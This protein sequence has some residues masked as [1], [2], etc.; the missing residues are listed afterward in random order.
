MIHMYDVQIIEPVKKHSGVADS[1]APLLVAAYCR[2]STK[3][4]AQ[5]KSLKSMSDYYRE[6]INSHEGWQLVDVYID[7]GKSGTK[8]GNRPELQRMMNDCR[9]GKI[10]YIITK[11]IS[12]LGRESE[13]LKM[14][15]QE[16][17]NRR[18]PIYFEEDRIDSTDPNC[19]F[20]LGIKSVISEEEVA[21]TSR[22]VALG[23]QMKMARGIMVG[24]PKCLGYDYNIE[25]KTI[26][27]NEEGAKTVRYIF[28]RYLNG[29]GCTVIARELNEKGIK[30]LRG[31]AWGT[32]SVAGIIKNE[33]YCG[34]LLQGK[35]VTI[36]PIN[37]VRTKNNGL[38]RQFRIENH[39]EP[40]ISRETFEQARELM[41]KRSQNRRRAA[42]GEIPRMKF[43]RQ[44]AFSSLLECGFC[45]KMLSRR[46]WHSGTPNQKTVWQCALATKKG[47]VFCSESKGMHEKIIEDA[48]L[49]AFSIIT[50]DNGEILDIFLKRVEKNLKADKVETEIR[51]KERQYEDVRN[52]LGKLIDS[53]L[54]GIIDAKVYKQKEAELCIERDAI[55][56]ELSE[57]NVIR[58]SNG[59]IEKKIEGMRKILDD[60]P[61][62][63]EF[64]RKIFE[65]VIEK[66]I[67]GGYTEDGCVDPY[68]LTF[69]F[70]TGYEYRFD[71]AKLRFGEGNFVM[72]CS[73]GIEKNVYSH[74]VDKSYSHHS[75]NSCGVRGVDVKS[76]Q[77]DREKML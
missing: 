31:N 44:Y 67:V 50:A 49:E 53:H 39:H 32:S 22:H 59:S 23:K 74:N 76:G 4:E 18:I 70:K 68:M 33:K 52:K 24:F 60:K 13:S 69:I 58:T 21:N 54:D 55:E 10:Q 27:I 71:N 2:V 30:T 9:E 37:K 20:E 47:K 62:L 36:D 42:Q 16:L 3:E 48:F 56:K 43:S 35:T 66:V 14:Y 8:F 63:K 41:E 40:I 73:D 57:L 65:S 11:S 61:I 46:S 51:K 15:V 25:T 45:H 19:R 17:T 7:E 26:T 64:D 5:L 29:A 34:E 1:A 38:A 77:V 12:R 75:Y 28:E 72:E 6:Y